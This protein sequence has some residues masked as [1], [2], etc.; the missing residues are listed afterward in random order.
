MT[1]WPAAPPSRFR[2]IPW[3]CRTA[4]R[5]FSGIPTTHDH[6]PLLGPVGAV[7]EQPVLGLLERG[8]LLLDEQRLASPVDDREFAGCD[9]RCQ[10]IRLD[11]FHGDESRQFPE[12]G[13]N[14][15]PECGRD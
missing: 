1:G 2:P 14:D 11:S 7:A 8:V 10:S 15:H 3:G 5:W 9:P 12:G 4:N 6:A 13:A